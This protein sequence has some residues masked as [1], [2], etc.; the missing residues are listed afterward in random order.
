MKLYKTMNYDGKM[1]LW[2]HKP[3]KVRIDHFEHEWKGEEP[4]EFL[5]EAMSKGLTTLATIEEVYISYD[6]E[7]RRRHYHP[8][9]ET[10]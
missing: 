5:G 7:T 3:T 2:M 9:N 10:K 1:Y 6:L 8:V 4:C